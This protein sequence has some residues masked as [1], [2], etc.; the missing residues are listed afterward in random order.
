MEQRYAVSQDCAGDSIATS[1]DLQ[2]A[3]VCVVNYHVVN[4]LQAFC[5]A[6][7]IS[8]D[9]IGDSIATL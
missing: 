5:T 6:I 8:R 7:L 3:K 1:V 4:S 9:C 2:Q